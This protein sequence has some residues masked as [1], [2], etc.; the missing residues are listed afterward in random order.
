[1]NEQEFWRDL[2]KLI[3]Q[4]AK[5]SEIYQTQWERLIQIRDSPSLST[6]L[7]IQTVCYGAVY[8]TQK[9][10]LNFPAIRPNIGLSGNQQLALE[11][12]L[13]N[14]PIALI[15]GSGAT[16]KTR[17]VNS[18]ANEAIEHFQ[19]VLILTH[20]SASLTKYG[21]LTTYPILLSKQQDYSQWV[22][23]Q[24]AQ[25]QMDYLPLHLLPDIELAKLRSPVKL[26]IWL[27]IIQNKSYLELTEL[28]KPE[29]PHLQQP[30]IQLLAYHLKKL[31]PLLKQQLNLSRAYNNLSEQAV[32]EIANQIRENRQVP[33]MGTVAEFMQSENQFLWET[34]FDFIIVEESHYL[35]WI[36]LMLLSGLCKKLVLFGEVIRN[37]SLQDSQE[38]L[39]FNR[40]P[41]CFKWLKYHLLPTYVYPLTEQFRVHS[42]IA[43]L[44][45]PCIC[46]DW[47]HTQSLNINYQ[48]PQT[49]QRLIWQDVPH[50]Q[51]GRRMIEF[52]QTLDIQLIS[53]IGI[54]TFSIE[55]R[56]YIKDILPQ[57]YD[58]IFV[59]TVAQWAGNEREIIM[60]N[61]AANPQDIPIEE[62]NITLTRGKDYLFLFGDYNLWKKLNS[63]IQELL[64]QSKL[65][66]ERLIVLS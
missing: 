1:M 12:A 30:R 54:I 5:I 22:I 52:I 56:D 34:N 62:M 18:L 8:L 58:K 11:M 10:H 38:T 47:V 57:D 66:K 25:P 29:F 40:F 13:S 3:Y 36:E 26:E 63:P 53:Q 14:S 45:Y 65:Y 42:E 55:Q 31:E 2:Q 43:N 50:D 61:C 37:Y 32:R 15:S 27:P 28:L 19:R 41:K 6:Q 64:N 39:F 51:V 60:I 35:T 9:A 46:D 21:N 49:I 4:S 24:L 16:G 17:I 33:V 48:L 7:I 44:V 59:D 23:D 20:H